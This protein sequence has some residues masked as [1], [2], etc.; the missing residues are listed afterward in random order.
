MLSITILSYNLNCCFYVNSNP[1]ADIWLAPN[2]LLCAVLSV[3]Y[4]HLPSLF[5]R[6]HFPPY[7]GPHILSYPLEISACHCFS[8]SSDSSTCPSTNLFP[9]AI[10]HVGVSSILP[11]L[12]KALLQHLSPLQPYVLKASPLS[13]SDCLKP[14]YL[15]LLLYPQ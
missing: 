8:L 10:K 3:P 7:S 15:V 11:I 9:L 14:C 4:C 6:Q 2:I 13:S 1:C 5:K 12:Q